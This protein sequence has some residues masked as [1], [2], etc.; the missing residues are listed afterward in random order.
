MT[1]TQPIEF[2]DF[3]QRIEQMLEEHAAACRV[4]V[5]AAVERAFP[6]TVPSTPKPTGRSRRPAKKARKSGSAPRL[7]RSLARRTPTE[8]AAV[9]ER[10]YQAVC[11]KPGESK[12]VLAAEM[13]IPAREL[14]RPMELLR[15]DGKVRSVGRRHLTRYFP[16]VADIAQMSAQPS[17]SELGLGEQ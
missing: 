7:V 12:A 16:L 6:T 15:R 17:G 2:P 4:A 8:M 10:L 5:L 1:K 11:S 9:V 13:R 14:D 3:S